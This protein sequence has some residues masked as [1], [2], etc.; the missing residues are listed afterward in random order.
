MCSSRNDS[1]PAD[2][3]IRQTTHGLA[4]RI[5]QGGIRDVG[6]EAR[7]TLMSSCCVRRCEFEKGDPFLD[8]FE[9]IRA[10]DA[11]LTRRQLAIAVSCA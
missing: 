4:G 2:T 7:I 1:R 9:I 10:N 3:I 6:T 11:V 8:E 5:L